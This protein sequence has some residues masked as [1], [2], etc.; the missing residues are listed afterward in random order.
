MPIGHGL[1][2]IDTGTD[3]R[4]HPDYT[5][6]LGQSWRC[7]FRGAHVSKYTVPGIATLLTLSLWLGEQWLSQR[8]GTAFATIQWGWLC[9]LS[10][11]FLFGALYTEACHSNSR[12]R[13]KLRTWYRIADIEGFVLAQQT[14]PSESWYEAKILLRFCGRRKQAKCVVTVTQYANHPQVSRKFVVLQ[15]QVAPVERDLRKQL[16]VASFPERVSKAI[17]PRSPYWGNNES[18]TWAGDGQHIVTVGIKSG[19]LPQQVEQFLIAAP[20]RP[21]A[22]SPEPVVLLG[23]FAEPE[24]LPL[25]RTR[26]ARR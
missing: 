26:Y 2:L 25:Q 11:S 19:I 17:P 4:D 23:N 1:L 22:S 10:T 20:R 5:S 24:C 6:E 13:S 3:R 16:V 21:S 18:L 9:A 8:F 7:A 14:S 12:L 15:E